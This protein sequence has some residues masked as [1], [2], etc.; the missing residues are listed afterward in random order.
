MFLVKGMYLRSEPVHPEIAG[1]G[2]NEGPSG[3]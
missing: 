1:H 2:W 3:L